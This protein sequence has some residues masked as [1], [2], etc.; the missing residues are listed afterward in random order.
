LPL[1]APGFTLVFGLVRIAHRLSFLCCVF[2]LLR[3]VYCVPNIA[4]FSGLSIL[5]CPSTRRVSLVDQEILIFPEHLSS[6]S[7]F[8]GVR[9]T[10]FLVIYVC[11]VDRCLS[12][13]T[14]SFGHC[15]VG[16]SSMYGF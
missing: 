16:S 14:F 15:V 7:V 9:V 2:I 1:Q 12:I 11:F 13:C 5:D 4:S 8:S 3:P 10:R 6:P